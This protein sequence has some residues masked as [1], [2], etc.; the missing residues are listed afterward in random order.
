MVRI[1][2]KDLKVKSNQVSF[3]KKLVQVAMKARS[4][5]G[6]NSF[7]KHMF[8]CRNVDLLHSGLLIFQKE[9]GFWVFM[10]YLVIYKC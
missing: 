5:K 1:F 3:T 9:L 4:K 8:L 7:I 10:Q 6:K 2:F